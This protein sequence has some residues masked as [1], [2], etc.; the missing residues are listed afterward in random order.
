[1]ED[2]DRNKAWQRFLPWPRVKEE[3]QNIKSSKDQRKCNGDEENRS[4]I[5]RADARNPV[6]S[7][8]CAEDRDLPGNRSIRLGRDYSLPSS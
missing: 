7:R 4:G 8:A 3:K 6:V 5:C 2:E 1:M